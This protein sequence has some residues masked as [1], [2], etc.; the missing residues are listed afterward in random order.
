M[1]VRD[2]Y[3]DLSLPDTTTDEQHV[4]TKKVHASNVEAAKADATDIETT[5][6]DAVNVEAIELD[7][8][9]MDTL[10]NCSDVVVPSAV[11]P[12]RPPSLR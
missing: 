5:E 11:P 1:H 3:D 4:E 8:G 7:T 2:Y 10:N 9:N 12:P 6:A